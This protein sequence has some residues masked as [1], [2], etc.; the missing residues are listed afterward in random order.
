MNG[1][2]RRA[3][4]T[5]RPMTMVVTWR[6]L[7]LT[8]G[9][10]ICL[11]SLANRHGMAM[12]LAISGAAIAAATAYVLDDPA[13]V[14]VAA[15]PTSLPIRRAQ[16]VAVAAAGAGVGWAVVVA[17][18]IRRSEMIGTTPATLDFAVLVAV[19]M[20]VSGAA[21]TMGDRTDGGIA[22]AVGSLACFAAAA[23]LPRWWWLPLPRYDAGGPGASVRVA[24]LLAVATAVL[25][26]TSRDPASLHEK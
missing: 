5:A 21:I 1:P 15:S 13:A 3:I 18:A 25:A 16:R 4:A 24:A 9:V 10:S 7:A 22:G 20:A 6:P 12:W 2:V 19:S 23:F 26:H 11:V 8:I 17:V 14:T